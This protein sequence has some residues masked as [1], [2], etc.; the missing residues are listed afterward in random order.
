[1]VPCWWLSLI[2]AAGLIFFADGSTSESLDDE[3][4]GTTL[5][6]AAWWPLC[7]RLMLMPRYSIHSPVAGLMR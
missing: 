2:A 6:F 4:D 7:W 3:S 5:N 1:M